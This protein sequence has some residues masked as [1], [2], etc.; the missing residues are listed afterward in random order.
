MF[1][2]F[3]VFILIILGGRVV[4][5]RS[6]SKNRKIYITYCSIVLL[7]KA[8]L[9]SV[10]IGRDTSHYSYYF[11]QSKN[12]SWAELINE[13]LERYQTISGGEDVG[14]YLLQKVFSTFIGD[15]NVYTFFIQGLLFYL[16]FGLF[17]YRNSKDNLQVMFAYVLFNA[18]FMGLHM[19]NARQV[20]AV[21][22]CIWAELFLAQKKYIKTVI[23]I[24]LGYFIHA[25][26]LLFFIPVVLSF[27]NDN[28][29]KYLSALTVVLSFFVLT[30]PNSVIVFMGNLLESDKYADYGLN[31][32]TG[33]AVTYITLSLMMC[34]FCLWAFW[35]KKD[36]SRP[37][38]LL[39]VMIPPTTLFVPLI[40]SNGAMMRITLYFQLFFV[41]LMPYAIETL[42]KKNYRIWYYILI[43][44]LV[45]LS[46][47]TTG[48]YRF[49]WEENQD[50]L[51][52]WT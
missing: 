14:Y 8:A 41:L 9:R 23:F 49:F 51:L 12:T 6:D 52:N 20:Y 19:A 40:Y 36:A 32:I 44:I 13:F 34:V 28:V 37:E 42:F 50:P 39:Y 7:L 29:L 5:S 16:P 27:L 18:L 25:S 11:Y 4:F 31:G 46:V 17:I 3:I 2:Q 10:T 22:F 24:I 48:E 30:D 26:A 43:A 38:R 47:S 35:I 21:G 15:F 45:I 1:V 33:G